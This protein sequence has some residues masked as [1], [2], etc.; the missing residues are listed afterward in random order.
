M[1]VC[2]PLI[3]KADKEDK[4]TSANSLGQNN[5]V[6]IYYIKASTT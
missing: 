6:Y 5:R 3:V 2:I 4:R 1:S